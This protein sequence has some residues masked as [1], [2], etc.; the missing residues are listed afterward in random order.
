MLQRDSTFLLNGVWV[1]PVKNKGTFHSGKLISVMRE[2]VSIGRRPRGHGCVPHMCSGWKGSWG[3][4]SSSAFAFQSV[5]SSIKLF[6]F[7]S[8]TEP[9]PQS[10]S[11]PELCLH[12]KHREVREGHSHGNSKNG[13]SVSE[14]LRQECHDPVWVMSI[15]PLMGNRQW[16]FVFPA[17]ESILKVA[18]RCFVG[19]CFF[20]WSYC[21]NLCD[22]VDWPAKDFWHWK[23]NVD[24]ATRAQRLDLMG[25]IS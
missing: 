13:A 23:E 9:P 20:S 4:C 1:V 16:G 17:C 7:I 6:F 21:N 14:E 8:F 3:G 10:T 11:W 25:S 12:P 22:Q 2:A 19:F 24:K 5:F 18:S 15:S